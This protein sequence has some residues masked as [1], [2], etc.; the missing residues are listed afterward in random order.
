MIYYIPIARFKDE[1][2]S[3]KLSI[4]TKESIESL[5]V[6]KYN[7]FSCFVVAWLF[8]ESTLKLLVFVGMIINATTVQSL[9]DVC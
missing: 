7:Y 6:H 2:V 9:P 1:I 3:L 4:N 8:R 5:V